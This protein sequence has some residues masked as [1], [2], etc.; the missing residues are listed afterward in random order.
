[1]LWANITSYVVI[2]AGA[3]LILLNRER[4][5]LSILGR[6]PVIG[7]GPE[8][9]YGSQQLGRIDFPPLRHLSSP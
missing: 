4:V 8:F 2:V 5:F 6:V 9:G 1:M 7:H 3:A